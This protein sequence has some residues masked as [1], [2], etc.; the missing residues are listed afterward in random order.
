VKKSCINPINPENFLN[1]DQKKSG[2][3]VAARGLDGQIKSLPLV[4]KI[5]RIPHYRTPNY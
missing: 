2:N 1:P 3:V 5:I 4:F